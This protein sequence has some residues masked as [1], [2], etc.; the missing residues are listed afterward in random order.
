MKA[1]SESIN[2]NKREPIE[3]K[4]PVIERQKFVGDETVTKS[5]F[6]RQL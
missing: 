1:Y 2:K 3:V 5:E 4:R 6:N